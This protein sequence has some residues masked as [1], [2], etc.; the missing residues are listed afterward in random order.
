MDGTQGRGGS[1]LEQRT[2]RGIGA[3]QVLGPALKGWGERKATPA[4]APTVRWGSPCVPAL[5]P[6]TDAKGMLVS[7]RRT[8]C[9][10]SRFEIAT[11]F[12]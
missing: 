3:R 6:G 2:V 1:I 9:L 10:M 7:Q 11:A 4:R 8:K 5:G 12:Q